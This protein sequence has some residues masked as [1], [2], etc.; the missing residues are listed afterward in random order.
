MK[1]SNKNSKWKAIIITVVVVVLTLGSV[2]VVATVFGNN[3]N[4]SLDFSIGAL[5]ENGEYVESDKSLYTK[6]AFEFDSVKVV[7]DF[8]ST[9]KY[10]LYYYDELDNF[11]SCSEELTKTSEITAPEGARFARI[12]ITP[13]FDSDVKKEDQIIKWYDV[14][15]YA[16]QLEVEVT[17]EDSEGETEEAA[18]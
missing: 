5:N 14:S 17:V 12:V 4:A 15:K 7:R 9:V 2:A 16:K 11:V 3:K 10:Q 8:E 13:M 1:Y 6:E 18:E